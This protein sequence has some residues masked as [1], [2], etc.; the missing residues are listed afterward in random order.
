MTIAFAD[1]VDRQEN[2]DLIR[3]GASLLL[4]LVF[5]VAVA[6]LLLPRE[7]AVEPNKP[8]PPAALLDLA[9]LPPAGAGGKPGSP[10]PPKPPLVQPAP[11]KP[12]VEQVKPP[13]PPAQ[14]I[15]PSVPPVPRVPPA[16]EIKP[17]VPPVP[18][19]QE[20]KPPV[21]RVPP[22]QEI[23]PP[24]PPIPKFAV[25]LPVAPPKPQ[26]LKPLPPRTAPTPP[27]QATGSAAPLLLD[28]M[29]VW[30]LAAVQRL[31]KFKKQSV[32]ASWNGEQGVV[33]LNIS[34]DRQGNI[35]FASIAS[36]SGYSSLDN[37]ALSMCRLAR[38]LPPLPPEFKREQYS[39]GVTIEFS[40]Y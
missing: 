28:P 6:W 27:P 20:I 22:A 3:W 38:R 37:Q 2:K 8:P 39:F 17:P 23:K 24:V 9:P 26:P 16:Q 7:A 34:I 4:V 5:H 40:L 18:P 25:P 11:P 32:A 33:G 10:P 19:A 30:Q 29:R 12:P 13:V 31:E 35:L 1:T 36:S 14:E 15:K 21:P